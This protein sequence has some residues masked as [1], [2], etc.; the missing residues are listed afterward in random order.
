MHQGWTDTQQN[1]NAKDINNIDTGATHTSDPEAQVTGG[2]HQLYWSLLG[3]LVWLLM[4][5]TDIAPVIG[6]L[7][8]P[9]QNHRSNA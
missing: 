7:Q 6:Y 3:A 8:R 9:A 2:I 5:R 1:H 4:T